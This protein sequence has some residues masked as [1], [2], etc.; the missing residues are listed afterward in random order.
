MLPALI[1]ALTVAAAPAL[2]QDPPDISPAKEVE[3]FAP[4]VGTWE[5]TGEVSH[6]PGM[7]SEKWTSK[8]TC[9]WILGGHFVREDVRIDFAAMPNPLEFINLYGWDRE[10]KRYVQIEINNLGVG[11]L[12]EVHFT[13][14]GKMITAATAVEMGEPVVERWVNTIGDGEV[15][16]L[17]HRAQGDGPFYEMVKGTAKRTD[18]KASEVNIAN[19][20]FM[21][22]I[23]PAPVKAISKLDGM[24]G[25]YKMK[26]WFMPAPGADKM[27]FS[28]TE[29]VR[30]IFGGT[31]I[32]MVTKGD[33]TPEFPIAYEGYSWMAWND[34]TQCF[35]VT[36]A[37]NMGEVSIQQGRKQGN[38]MI[39]NAAAMYQ[40]Q[41]TSARG[42]LE[43]AEDGSFHSI[44]GHH[45]TGTE[46]PML[47]FEGTYTKQ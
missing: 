29:T 42:V 11:R 19:A 4:L 16:F 10:N 46:K 15:S 23:M 40:G 36:Y 45:L 37:N 20:A 18:K 6:G 9:S 8:S 3:K 44:T 13:A 12:N 5:G 22:D 35:D 38:K 17:G 47:V 7:P 34:H 31:V 24:I 21:P 26:G 28:G 43:L 39:M 30:K 32:E 2:A 25:D 14:N 33:K 1:T 27:E 41:P